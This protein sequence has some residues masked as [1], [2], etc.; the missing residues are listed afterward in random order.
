MSFG[1]VPLLVEL[2]HKQQ[3]GADL[4]D[5]LLYAHPAK[6]ILNPFI[7]RKVLILVFEISSQG[8]RTCTK[9]ERMFAG[10]YLG[11]C[12]SPRNIDLGF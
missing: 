12:V 2:I 7:D 4:G 5:F 3:L 6:Q 9:I 1:I 8:D 10:A 11:I